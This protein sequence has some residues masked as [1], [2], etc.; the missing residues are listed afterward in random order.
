MIF[1]YSG[2]EFLLLLPN[3]SLENATHLAERIREDGKK[4]W[5]KYSN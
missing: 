3:T 2:E 1:R 5:E 4:Q